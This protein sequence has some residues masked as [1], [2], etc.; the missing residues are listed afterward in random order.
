[1]R[2]VALG[3]IAIAPSLATLLLQSVMKNGWR[4]ND[5]HAY[6][7]AGRLVARGQNPYDLAAFGELARIEGIPSVVGGGYSYPPL[8]AVL[9]EPLAA[10]PFATAGWVFT[11]GSVLAFGI[12]V[13]GLL[14]S[15]PAFASA[16]W[17]R[18]AAG[19]LALGLYPPIITSLF[20]GQVNLIV[21]GLLAFG[22]FG[23]ASMPR[24][25][26]AGLALG[27]AAGIKLVPGLLL[28]PLLLARRW[29]LATGMLLAIFLS[30]VWPGSLRHGLY[31]A[32][33]A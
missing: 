10:L 33:E 16:T 2:G 26:A 12:T 31:A 15:T 25:I 29:T 1:M 13:T 22:L 6:W 32:V 14:R 27:L 21:L 23:G 5:F 17:R 8:F 3:L 4:F 30:L 28:V 7:L 18:R 19:A 24:T 11:T 9:M 20:I